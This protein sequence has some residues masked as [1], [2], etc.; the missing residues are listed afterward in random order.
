M[1]FVWY[2]NLDRSFFRFV[3]IYAFDS[4]TDRQTDGH[5]SHCQ[6]APAFHAARKNWEH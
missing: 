2:K 3:T 4:R 6:S 1:I 5:L